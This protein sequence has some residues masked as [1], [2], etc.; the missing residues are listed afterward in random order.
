MK[1]EKFSG[2]VETAYGQ[3]LKT[4]VEFSGTYEAFETFKEAEDAKELLSNDEHLKVINNSRKANARMKA[5]TA[6]L[7]AAG[8]QKPDPN[9][10]EEIRKRMIADAMKGNA[11]L[12]NETAA[13]LVDSLLSA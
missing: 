7:D 9:S 10:A 5:T 3:T 12:T 4:P 6:A 2:K 11:K 13:A 1:P 8:I